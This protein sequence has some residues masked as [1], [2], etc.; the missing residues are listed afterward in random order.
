MKILLIG[1]TGMVGSR[2]A[3]EALAR[4]HEVTAATRSGRPDAL[5]EN[6]ALT[7]VPLDASD[8]A[9]VAKGAAGHDAV[10]S[11]ISPP[12]DGSDP[13]A[14][15]LATYRS[16]IEG[17]RTADVGRFLIVGGAGSL[18]TPSGLDRVDTPDFPDIYKP[19][20]SAL[21]EVLRLFRGEVTDLDW[22]FVSPAD[23]IGPGERTALF[24]LGGD[25]M[26]YAPDGS[27]TISAEDFAVALVDELEKGDAIRRRITVA[28]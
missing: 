2:I 23:E 27:S 18:Q 17:L 26:L 20:S 4:G 24:R 3:A 12:R 8:P 11:A 14:S 21:R 7:T 6:P 5:P 10:V 9:Q 13:T 16:L 25:Q 28:Y 1:A 22:T 15:L 19:E